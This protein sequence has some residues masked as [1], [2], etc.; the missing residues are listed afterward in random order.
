MVR[1][2]S[3]AFSASVFGGAGFAA[4][5]LRRKSR[6]KTRCG[7]I[8]A[9][10]QRIN[11]HERRF[12]AG[13]PDLL[14]TFPQAGPD[15]RHVAATHLESISMHLLR[16]LRRRFRDRNVVTDGTLEAEAKAL[17]SDRLSIRISQAAGS[18]AGSA[19]LMTPTPGVL[20][21]HEGERQTEGHS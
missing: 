16:S 17:G 20:H 1:S 7:F 18:T 10:A 4:A 14:V 19:G 15:E 21:P 5:L 2:S 12:R 9:P 13:A 6:P 8:D 3:R 11:P